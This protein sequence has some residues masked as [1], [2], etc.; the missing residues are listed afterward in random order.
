M[1]AVALAGVA[2]VFAFLP[3]GS[4]A[5]TASNDK[6]AGV[7]GSQVAGHKLADAL[8]RE[9]AGAA[10]GAGQATRP[11][12]HSRVSVAR[13]ENPSGSPTASPSASTSS[14]TAG[15]AARSALGE[16]VRR[17]EEGG[18]YAWGRGNGGGAYQFELGTWEHYGGA[19][20]AYGTAG[21]AYQDRIF[22]NAVTAGGASNWTNYDGC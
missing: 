18:S 11:G 16:C 7:T 5:R 8:L 4:A 10:R 1:A 6:A 13:L 12:Q 20:S 3:G 21:P 9:A 22:D 2:A 15:D 14:A 19:A 17:A